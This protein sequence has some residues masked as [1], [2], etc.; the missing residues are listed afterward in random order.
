M[1]PRRIPFQVLEDAIRET[2]ERRGVAP[3]DGRVTAR[4]LLEAEA[5]GYPAQGVRRVAEMCSF[6]DRGNLSPRTDF[7]RLEPAPALRLFR[8]EA[9]LG[10][11]IA[12]QAADAA[13][14]LARSFGV[15]CV[16]VLGAGHIG[17]LTHYAE[18]AA[19]TGVFCFVT[20]TSSPA[21]SWPGSGVPLLGTNAMA[22]AFPLEDGI[23][24]ADFATAEVA[25]GE[26]LERFQAGTRFDRDVG[27][28]PDGKPSR[29]PAEI[30]RGGILPMG[31]H[32]KGALISLLLSTLAGPLVGGMPNHEVLGTRWPDARPNKTDFFLALD[33][34]AF[35][36][37]ETFQIKMRGFLEALTGSTPDFHV[38]G[39]HSR[40]R[41]E[42]A[43]RNGFEE[44]A[45]VSDLLALASA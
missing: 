9:A 41:W 8:C 15:G 40:V 38:P 39:Q 21:V 17:Y 12:V 24:C 27:T 19:A 7:E 3:G 44:T 32:R 29:D 5:R 1:P 22:Y 25:R 30:L 26:V 34:A 4:V 2:L 20:T 6:L 28:G 33:I 11:P 42:E 37:P 10:H 13:A 36:D 45:D 23:L 43:L 14:V 16:A 35:G 18:R 31:G